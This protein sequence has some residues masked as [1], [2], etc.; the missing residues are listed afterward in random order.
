[1]PKCGTMALSSTGVKTINQQSCN[2]NLCDCYIKEYINML[3]SQR[4]GKMDSH[5]NYM[6]IWCNV[7]CSFAY[8]YG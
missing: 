4:R 3:F 2:I 5:V 6:Y 7:S 1:M 8:V